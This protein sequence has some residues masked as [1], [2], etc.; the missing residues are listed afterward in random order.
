LEVRQRNVTPASRHAAIVLRDKQE[1]G[2]KRNNILLKL[3][4]LLSPFSCVLLNLKDS[5]TVKYVE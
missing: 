3:R 4:E 5:V 1:K 2:K